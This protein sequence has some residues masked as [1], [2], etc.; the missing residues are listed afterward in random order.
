ML[1]WRLARLRRGVARG[2]ATLEYVAAI[3]V[4]A[5][6]IA[7]LALS[8]S[9]AR[10]RLPQIVEHAVCLVVTAIGSGSCSAA[11]VPPPPPVQP[12]FDPKPAKCKLGESSEKVNSEFKIGF[13]KI[14]NNAGFV[15][16]TYNDGTVTY[17][18][19]DGASVGLTASTPGG[20]FDAGKLKGGAS[21][22]FGAGVKFDYGSTWTFKDAAEAKA[23]KD[24]LDAYLAQSEADR[25]DQTGFGS[26]WRH[27]LGQ[28]VDP[29]KPP[30]QLVGTVEV[31]A[32][33]TGKIGLGLPF[34]QDPNAKSGIPDLKL[35]EAGVK[36]NSTDKWTV[37]TDTTTGAK[38]YTTGND[39]YNQYNGQLGPAAGEYKS[40]IGS[41]MA[42]TRDKNGQ[43]SKVALVTTREGKATGT[44]NAGQ[45]DL[46][47][48][49]SQSDSD[50][51]VTVT[52]TT[53]DVSTPEQRALVDGWLAAQHR[54]PNGYISPETFFPDHPV[55]GD[56]F[57]NLMY[58]NATVS[59]VGYDNVT[60]KQGFAAE[61]KLGV[62][63]GVDFSLETTDSKAREATYLGAPDAG[64]SRT[65]VDFPECVSK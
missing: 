36:F 65:P 47:G 60:D 25:Y 33:V 13:I 54:D 34:D 45:K 4:A 39:T 41:S 43:I 11:D 17:T 1:R 48:K 15:V 55:P 31:N 53:L 27:I 12:P 46:G 2:A 26:L 7:A 6:L 58:T 22:D 49:V 29:P 10:S 28:N 50:G 5:I 62:S 3:S 24:Q 18:A 23:M 30:S 51:N 56:P 63:F 8:L 61:V 40:L 52:T 38:T 32:D 14:G 42:I 21:V 19:T 64:G 37:I 20:K 44:L 57:Q 9:P 59:N 35:G 16:T